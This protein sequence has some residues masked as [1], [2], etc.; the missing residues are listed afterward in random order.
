MSIGEP[1]PPWPPWR[2]LCQDPCF[3]PGWLEGAMA[4]VVPPV[5][6]P[7]LS[8]PTDLD[9]RFSKANI[10]DLKFNV[11]SVVTPRYF[12]ESHNEIDEVL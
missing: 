4:L 3:C 5:A 7:M 9:T 2:R 6:T 10:G 12:A 8:V 1:H 11:L